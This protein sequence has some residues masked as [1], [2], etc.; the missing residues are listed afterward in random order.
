MVQTAQR[1]KLMESPK[2][3]LSDIVEGLK[4]DGHTCNKELFSFINRSLNYHG[5]Q[6]KLTDID[7]DTVW[8]QVVEIGDAAA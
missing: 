7:H 5:C 1:R 6:A 3:A 2:V 8:F 4:Q